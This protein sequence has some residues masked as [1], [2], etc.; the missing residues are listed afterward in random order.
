MPKRRFKPRY[1]EVRKNRDGSR[2]YYWCPKD[3]PAARL[4]DDPDEA[5][6]EAE[7]KNQK[8]DM[9]LA[10]IGR[11]PIKVDSI[12]WL[13]NEYRQDPDFQQLAHKTKRDY[14]QNLKWLETTFGDLSP[15]AIGADTIQKLKR[16]GADKPFQ[17]NARI[18]TIRLLYAWGMRNSKVKENP[19]ARFRQI[20]TEARDVVWHRDDIAAFLQTARPSMKLAVLLGCFTLQREGDLIALLW[21]AYDGRRIELRQR[22]TKKLIAAAVHTLLKAAL[23]ATPRAA[24]TVLVSEATGKPYDEH[25]FRHVFAQDRKA[26]G[27]PPDLQF[28][29]LRRTGAVTLARLGVKLQSIAALGGWTISRTSKILET[30]IPL[31]E[32][33]ASAAVTAMEESNVHMLEHSR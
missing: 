22:K 23:D 31:D 30:Y 4:S 28:R 14:E 21:S 25:H 24:E 29:D 13:I 15:S 1:L 5:W 10:G 16:V 32:E 26:A 33:M 7:A 2:R 20:T 3:Q 17:T 11:Q 27:L 19:A 12:T 8:R 18:R 6:R 9:E